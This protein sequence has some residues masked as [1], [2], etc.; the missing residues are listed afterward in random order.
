MA[1]AKATKAK[2]D[3]KK[4][5]EAPAAALRERL[6]EVPSELVTISEARGEAAY[7]VVEQLLHN[8]PQ[9]LC[10][11]IMAASFASADHLDIATVTEEVE[12]LFVKIRFETPCR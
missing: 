3:A 9:S 6:R 10:R 7:I 12:G 5:A 4:T 1:K 8:L 11:R 2:S